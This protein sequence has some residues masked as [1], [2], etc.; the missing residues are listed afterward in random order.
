MND[1]LPVFAQ[2]RV[3]SSV[4][5]CYFYHSMDIPD[6]GAVAGEWD[7]RGREREYLGGVDLAGKT[8]LE[9]GTASGH[10]CFWMEKQGAQ[11]SAYDLSENQE[12]DLVPYSTHDLTQQIRGRKA[13]MRKI[14][15]SWW[16]AH[17]RFKSKARVAYGTV[18]DLSD[19]L[20]RFDV[21]TLGSILRH[22]RDPFLAM[23][24]AASVSLDTMIVTD[25]P[26]PACDQAIALTSNGRLV[27]FLPD[28]RTGEPLE[29]WWDLSPNF[30]AEVLQMLGFTDLTE[31]S[32]R[33]R[34]MGQE[35][36]LFT[37]VARK[38]AERRSRR[39]AKSAGGNDEYATHSQIMDAI[40]GRHVLRHLIGRI[41]KRLG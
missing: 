10:L 38:G 30:I 24:R 39:S 41:R 16:F 31:T 33:Q 5:D 12:W 2:A 19:K 25:R 14:N 32:H 27:R 7:L 11:M 20:G 13:H 26:L 18:Y 29:T 22:L 8:V 21:V 40:P 1:Q 35:R 17:E 23:Q 37:I 6:H 34:C 3:V 36:D 28:A 9:I 4:E 15:N